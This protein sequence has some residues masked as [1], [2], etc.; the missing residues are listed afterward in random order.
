M[1]QNALTRETQ[2]HVAQKE[3]RKFKEQLKNCE[4][5]RIQALAELDKAKKEVDGLTQ[6]LEIINAS[7]KSSA[8][9]N[10][11]IQSEQS[12][13]MMSSDHPDDTGNPWNEELSNAREQYLVAF[14]DIGSAKQDLRRITQESLACESAKVIA[15][16]EE[17]EAK[18]LA[19][20]NI[21]RA[22]QLS[23]DIAT[24]QESIARVE[25]ASMLVKQEETVI[26]SGKETIRKAHK[27][28]L[29]ESKNKILSLRK[30]F[31]PETGVIDKQQ[32]LAETN[33]EIEIVKMEMKK[34]RV[35]DL[36]TVKT[37]TTEL[38]GAKGVLQKVAEEERSLQ[39]LLDSLKLELESVKKERLELNEK[40]AQ[41]ELTA[42]N[43]NAHLEKRKFEL[44]NIIAG[45]EKT[46]LACEE[47]MSTLHKLSL[48][49][50][51]AKRDAEN[52]KNTASQLRKE[53]ETIQIS[54]EEAEKDLE[55]A[56]SNAEAAKATEANALNEIKILNDKANAAR[57]S[58]SE[59]GAKIT[60]SIEEHE[61]LSRKV[62]ESDRLA[63]MK[64]AAAM[65]QVEAVKASENEVIQKLEACRKEI[66]EMKLTTE[67][68][69]KDAEMAEK[70]MRAIG[71]ELKKWR[72]REDKKASE[73]ASRILEDTE[74]V[75]PEETSPPPVPNSQH[76]PRK[77]D[78]KVFDKMPFHKKTSRIPTLSAIFSRRK[79]NVSSSR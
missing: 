76:I 68:A 5:T 54:L 17:T 61:S 11:K 27:F 53:I 8:S 16:Q 44:E 7:K 49:S 58:T 47:M 36:N 34:V 38:D 69:L 18:N 13:E 52:M 26:I 4:T 33:A 77:K 75:K 31:N 56:L 6:K 72:E 21:E 3:L 37:V 62:D 59:S 25:S 20:V 23:N 45:E 19:S 24:V 28:A 40:E 67:T 15:L 70:A 39:S 41:T 66:E 79:S 32:K 46:R 78:E 51:N 29:E 57:T 65:A 64:V 30:E 73:I 9:E 22:N 60:I 74:M 2:L 71:G 48:D 10:F 50:S 14:T 1:L 43:L 12:E 63:E 42:A 55:V 35:S